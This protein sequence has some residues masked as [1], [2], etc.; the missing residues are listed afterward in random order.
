MAS[1]AQTPRRSRLRHP[2]T[3]S[4]SGIDGAGKSTQIAM[5]MDQLTREGYSFET[6]RFWDDIAV[7][8]RFRET[9]AQVLFR[10]DTGV[11]S[12]ERPLN[13]RDKNVQS[14]YMTPARFF[15]YLLD[16][17]SLNSVYRQRQHAEADV[18]IFDR[19]MYDELANLRLGSIIGRTFARFI[20]RIIPRPDIAYLLDVDPDQARRRKPEYPLDFLH[21]NREAY[22]KL[23]SLTHVL[24][25]VRAPTLQETS[26]QVMSEMWKGLHAKE[27]M[28]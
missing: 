14:W 16:A 2:F 24:T 1:T 6:V 10:G 8:K 27:L 11:G 7:L 17:M 3:V 5:L 9:S 19:Y 12:P 22:L 18:I 28:A 13:R 21:I 4:F 20:S 23:N 26:D 15:I 25:V